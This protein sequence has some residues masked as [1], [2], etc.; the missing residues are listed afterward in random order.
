MF[1][2][3]FTSI[4]YWLKLSLMWFL[5]ILK[6]RCCFL[7]QLN[8]LNFDFMRLFPPSTIQVWIARDVAWKAYVQVLLLFD[9]ALKRQS[10]FE[11][12]YFVLVLLL[13][14]ILIQ[15]QWNTPCQSVFCRWNHLI[16][17]GPHSILL[18][19]FCFTKK[20]ARKCSFGFWWCYIDRKVSTKSIEK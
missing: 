9:W 15:L 16:L 10:W 4:F 17:L 5:F 8:Q 6:S 20:Q 12:F 13:A 11:I 18:Y 2:A 14:I 19:A 7:E 3:I 1:S